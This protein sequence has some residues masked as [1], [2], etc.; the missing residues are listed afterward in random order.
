MFLRCV[1]FY[2]ALSVN[3]NGG[4]T[5]TT[6]S[7]DT[8]EET[9]LTLITLTGGAVAQTAPCDL[10][11]SQTE[12]WVKL[13]PANGPMPNLD[14]DTTSMYSLVVE[15]IDG[16]STTQE[17]FTVNIDRNNSPTISNLYTGKILS[18]SDFLKYEIG[19]YDLRI[20]VTDS[21]NNQIGPYSLTVAVTDFCSEGDQGYNCFTLGYIHSLNLCEISANE[22]DIKAKCYRSMRTNEALHKVNITVLTDAKIISDSNCTCVAGTYNFSLP[23]FKLKRDTIRAIC[24]KFAAAIAQTKG[25]E[26]KSTTCSF[27]DSGKSTPSSRRKRKP[28]FTKIPQVDLPGSSTSAILKLKEDDDIPLSYLL[29]ENATTIDTR[30]GK[31]QT[32]SLLYFRVSKI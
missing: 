2:E 31:V 13:D 25:G 28:V 26:N 6:I 29:Q 16:V 8:T 5:T 7:E 24:N 4:K 10:N 1:I 9:Q 22:V 27:N 12:F 32:G 17:T 15:C 21:H 23:E 30:L 14:F 18:T 11:H 20:T 19:T 3:F